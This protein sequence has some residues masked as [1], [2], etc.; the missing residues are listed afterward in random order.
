LLEYKKYLDYV[1]K[2]I[3][4]SKKNNKSKQNSE[5]SETEEIMEHL[6]IKCLFERAISDNQNCLDLSL[7]LKYIYYL[8]N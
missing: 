6:E 7:W 2:K 1:L 4:I 3:K 5:L 8:V